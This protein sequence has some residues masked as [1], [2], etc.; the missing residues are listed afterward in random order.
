[1][2]TDLY[3]PTG[4]ETADID[5][6]DAIRGGLRNRIKLILANKTRR[7]K[8]EYRHTVGTRTYWHMDEY[9]N[10][11]LIW[12]DSILARLLWNGARLD[13]PMYLPQGSVHNRVFQNVLMEIGW[14]Y[15]HRKVNGV[16]EFG[17]V[18]RDGFKG[19]GRVYKFNMDNNVAGWIRLESN[20]IVPYRYHD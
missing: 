9:G 14:S 6:Y 12:G 13:F 15:K 8:G 11:E 5:T 4:I 2:H 18:P 16:W 1:M 19:W 7:T 20:I 3:M 17:L 10:P